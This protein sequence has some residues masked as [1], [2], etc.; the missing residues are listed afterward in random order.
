MYNNNLMRLS[1]FA[2]CGLTGIIEYF[3]LAL[4]KHKK[5]NILTQKKLNAYMYN[6]LRYPLS[7]YS[8]IAAYMVYIHNPFIIDNVWI[9]IYINLIIFLNG[10]FYN[11]LTIENYIKYKLIK[12]NTNI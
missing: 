4:V 12:E 3:T 6:Y 11:K 9:F 2:S 5:L 10:S 7:I 8:I 1:I